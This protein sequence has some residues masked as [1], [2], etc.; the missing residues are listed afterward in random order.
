MQYFSQHLK[1]RFSPF[2]YD[3]RTAWHFANRLARLRIRIAVYLYFMMGL[4]LF[5]ILIVFI[6]HDA[7]LE[8]LRALSDQL[9]QV[10]QRGRFLY[11]AYLHQL[12]VDLWEDDDWYDDPTIRWTTAI[13]ILSAGVFLKKIIE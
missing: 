4:L 1:I 11:N 13:D 6:Y 10:W 8:I 12:C 5:S 3:I 2:L 9:P 7:L